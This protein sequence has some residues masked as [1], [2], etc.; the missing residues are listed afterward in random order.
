MKVLEEGF[1]APSFALA[2]KDNAVHR[3]E[4]LGGSKT[5]LFF[6]PKDNTP[7]CTIEARTFSK[8]LAKFEAIKARV[9]GISGGDAKSK[10]KFCAQNNLKVLLLSDPD[11]KVARKYGVYGEKSFMGRSYMGIARTTFVLDKKGK[12]LKVFDKVKPET[13]AEEVLE[14]LAQSRKEKKIS[15]KTAAKT[16]TVKKGTK[17]ASTKKTTKK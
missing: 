11:Y 10:Q 4:D 12:I 17:K 2:D 5:I 16:K 14:F 13:H 3:L 9:V 1:Q 6:Y 7:G 8:D 15:A